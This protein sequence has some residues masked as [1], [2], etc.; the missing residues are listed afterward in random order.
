MEQDLNRP[1]ALR[2]DEQIPPFGTPLPELG[3]NRRK[4][5]EAEPLDS[6]AKPPVHETDVFAH[7]SP[8]ALEEIVSDSTVT[9]DSANKD[10]ADGRWKGCSMRRMASVMPVGEAVVERVSLPPLSWVLLNRHSEKWICLMIRSGPAQTPRLE[11]VRWIDYP[12]RQ[13]C[14][15]LAAAGGNG[16]RYPRA[17]P[18]SSDSSLG[19]AKGVSARQAGAR[20]C[21]ILNSPPLRIIRSRLP[22]VGAA[23]G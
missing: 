21:P 2:V 7:T 14:N 9:D 4:S 20:G 22:S 12:R 11:Q 15:E 16:N 6:L 1:A 23:C 13:R 5:Q 17:W 3:Q 18:A 10:A 8:P 19:F